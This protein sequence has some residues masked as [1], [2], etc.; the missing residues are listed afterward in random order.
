ME[1]SQLRLYY[2][3]FFLLRLQ[4][5]GF[6]F[7]W[8]LIG[9]GVGCCRGVQGPS[10][11]SKILCR[12]KYRTFTCASHLRLFAHEK[13]KVT[14]KYFL[15]VWL[16]NCWSNESNCHWEQWWCSF[17][18]VFQLKMS[19]TRYKRIWL[20]FYSN[21]LVLFRFSVWSLYIKQFLQWSYHYIE[22]CGTVR[23]SDLRKC[24]VCC[25]SQMFVRSLP[26]WRA[27]YKMAFSVHE[28]ILSS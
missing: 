23:S 16:R 24:F 6:Q 12:L 14:A 11:G 7:Q 4:Y 26:E 17:T 15:L 21:F 27:F 28:N 19:I 5:G 1:P 2:Y 20:E 3:S 8:H 13:Q 9:D 10:D 18:A 22:V 25:T